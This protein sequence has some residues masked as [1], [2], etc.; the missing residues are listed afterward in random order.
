MARM[1]TS[2]K[3]EMRLLA[4]RGRV[5]WLLIGIAALL[6]LPSVLENQ[7]FLGYGLTNTQLLGVGLPQVNYAL[8][9]I[10]AAI[11]LNLLVGY[12]GLLSLGHA[13]FFSVGAITAAVLDVQHGLPFPLVIL[14]A[15]LVGAAVGAFFGL[16]SLRLRGLYLLLSTFA[17]HFIALYVFREYQNR[18]FGFSGISFE[19]PSVFGF[20]FDSETKWYYLLV[21]AAALTLL[22]SRNLLNTRE[23]RSLVAI[24][25]HDVA[26]G[27]LGVAV[28]RQRIKS[29][30]ITSFITSA[31]GALYVYYLG[32]TTYEAYSLEFVINYFAIIIIGGMGSLLG[33]VLGAV[34]WILLPQILQTFAQNVSPDAPVIGSLLNDYQGQTV[35]TLLG[36]FVILIMIFKPGG[37]NEFWLDIKRGVVKWPYSS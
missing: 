1:R 30:A 25:D 37:L 10:V 31:V 13:A 18:N 14:A 5:I 6:Y 34:V 16:P 22:T 11:A 3:Q 12:T 7:A 17:L 28:G 33:S 24:R 8:I 20:T 15:G 29:F 32:T 19:A 9:A 26:A 2:Y 27:A 4:S 23:G 21:V 36:L 35:A